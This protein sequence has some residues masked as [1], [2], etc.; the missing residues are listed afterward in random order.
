MVR[1]TSQRNA[2]P[3]AGDHWGPMRIVYLQYASDPIVFYDPY[4]FYR[5]PEWMAVPRGPDVSP[6]F[7]WYPV[8]TF[9]QLTL[10]LAADSFLGVPLG[11][12]ADAS[13]KAFVDMV[14]ASV[15]VVRKPLPFTAMGRGVAGRKFLLDYFTK[16][17]LR[18]R[19]T[20]GG[21]DMFSQF[22]TA[23]HEDGSLMPVDEV[24][25]LMIFL[26][27]AARVNR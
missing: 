10:D 15:G 12:E 23:T 20:G 7:A 17:T 5:Q 21:Q 13:N 3:E 2:L 24:V 18:R 8:V 25:D 19:E 22:A 27:M 4:S 14:A 11:A 1:F 26:M 16:E 6:D 9:L